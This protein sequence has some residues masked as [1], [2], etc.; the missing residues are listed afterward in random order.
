MSEFK[1][2][3]SVEEQIR[4]FA[5]KHRTERSCAEA[6][7][8]ISLLAKEEVDKSPLKEEMANYCIKAFPG[9]FQTTVVATAI[10]CLAYRE[11]KPE[12]GDLTDYVKWFVK[13]AV[14]LAGDDCRKGDLSD[15]IL[16]SPSSFF[17]KISE[18][19]KM[20]DGDMK[21]T[22]KRFGLEYSEKMMKKT[23]DINKN[24]E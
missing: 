20:D 22:A 14:T 3:V 19:V 12:D 18:A 21:R 17:K 6:G 2:E 15:S 9:S 7:E 8:F 1:N 13:S 5:K 24:Y 4:E 11:Y 23:M 16:S 10:A